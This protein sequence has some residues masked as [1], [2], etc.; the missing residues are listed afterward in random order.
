LTIGPEG[1]GKGKTLNPKP[2]PRRKK[3]WNVIEGKGG[4]EETV[5]ACYSSRLGRSEGKGEGKTG[6]T[7]L[8]IS[9]VGDRQNSEEEKKKR[10]S[11]SSPVTRK[12]TGTIR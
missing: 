7:L 6:S 11:G 8:H 3:K 1:E 5:I 9:L 2:W 4:G 12:L 10:R